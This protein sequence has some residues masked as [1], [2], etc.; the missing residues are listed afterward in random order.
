MF[1]LAA[2]ALIERITPARARASI[3]QG[4]QIA[5]RGFARR[6]RVVGKAIAQVSEGEGA[7][8]GQRA[9]GGQRAGE[10]AEQGGH[11]GGRLEMALVINPQPPPRCFER[12]LKPDAGEHVE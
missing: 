9:G 8:L 5:V 2:G 7:A 10:I 11:R 4:S 3:A 12:G 6:E 1:E